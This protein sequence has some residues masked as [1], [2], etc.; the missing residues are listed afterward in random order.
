MSKTTK[1]PHKP[2]TAKAKPNEGKVKPTTGKAQSTATKTKTVADKKIKATTIRPSKKKTDQ[3]THLT[4]KATPPSK[5]DDC[6]SREALCAEKCQTH[7]GCKFLN[8]LSFLRLSPRLN[9]Q[10]FL[11]LHI[12]WGIIYSLLA[13]SLVNFDL[14]TDFATQANNLANSNSFNLY[15]T[16]VLCIALPL[17]V[18]N[19]IFL[20]IRRL[21]DCNL[22]GWWLLVCLVPLIGLFWYIAIYFIPGTKGSNRFGED[23]LV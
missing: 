13:L 9:R 1:K 3:T 2:T 20:V 22:R 19:N 21:N 11:I 15:Q 10:K 23:P 18:I 16:L 8:Y 7:C 5:I 12:I 17:L 4:T 6:S 14:E